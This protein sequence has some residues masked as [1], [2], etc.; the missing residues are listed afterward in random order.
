MCSRRRHGSLVF[1]ERSFRRLRT[2][3]KR[4]GDR[5]N[6]KWRPTTSEC[7]AL[8]RSTTTL[9]KRHQNAVEWQHYEASAQ[10]DPLFPFTF[11]HATR[12]FSARRRGRY[13]Q[14]Q[15]AL[16]CNRHG[17]HPGAY[18]C[19][20]RRW[21]GGRTRRSNPVWHHKAITSGL[22][23]VSRCFILGGLHLTG[24][25]ARFTGCTITFGC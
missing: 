16:R 8:L 23:F 22:G 19:R 15:R 17:A 18:C 1:Q 7:A 10:K 6:S 11:S 5:K 9:R 21:Q 24:V 25:A 20:P 3:S 13:P 2:H 4:L 14:E 12:N